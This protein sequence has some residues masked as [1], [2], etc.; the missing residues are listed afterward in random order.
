MLPRTI[1]LLSPTI[2]SNPMAVAF[3]NDP[4][5][6]WVQAPK[7]VLALFANGWPFSVEPANSPNAVFAFAPE[8]GS[9]S[10]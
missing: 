4:A 8:R 3:E 2:A 9:A 7:K 1:A 6:V 5:L 10:E